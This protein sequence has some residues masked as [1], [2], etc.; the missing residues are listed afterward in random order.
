ML[1]NSKKCLTFRNFLLNIKTQN[2]LSCSFYLL[3]IIKKGNAI[4][5]VFISFKKITSLTVD[6]QPEIP[7]PY[8][9]KNCRFTFQ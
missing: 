8:T 2:L 4:F 9:R 6:I 7:T 5:M 3:F 1:Q